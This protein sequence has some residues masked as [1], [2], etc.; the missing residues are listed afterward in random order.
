[1]TT[2]MAKQAQAVPISPK[3]QGFD[4]DTHECFMNVSD[5]TVW[6]DESNDLVSI[7][8]HWPGEKCQSST[9]LRFAEG[10][11]MSSLEVWNANGKRC[12]GHLDGKDLVLFLTRA[13][14]R[15]CYGGRSGR[16]ARKG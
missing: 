2:A 8:R 10:G 4:P 3:A 11:E 16:Q 5:P 14:I 9:Q 1:M 12:L 13:R 7:L 6:R 15:L